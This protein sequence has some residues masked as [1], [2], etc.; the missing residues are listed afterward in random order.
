MYYL[1][2]VVINSTNLPQT[3][4]RIII[5]WYVHLWIKIVSNA[6]GQE[7]KKR[8]VRVDPITMGS[9]VLAGDWAVSEEKNIMLKTLQNT[10]TSD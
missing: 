10:F 8:R 1:L 7:N 6:A 5:V 9:V 2:T 3:T 4:D